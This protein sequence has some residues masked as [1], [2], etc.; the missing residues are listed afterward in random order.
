MVPDVQP[1]WGETSGTIG[2]SGQVLLTHASLQLL[3]QN[4]G[5]PILHVKGPTTDPDLR[6]EIR[7]ATDAD[8]LVP[9]SGVEQMMTAMAAHGWSFLDTFASGS[10]FGH[11]ATARHKTWGDADIHRHMPGTADPDRTFAKFSDRARV[12]DLAGVPCLVL[13]RVDQALVI[14]LHAARSGLM[15][16]ELSRAF[17]DVRAT[18][19]ALTLPEREELQRR[20]TE[21]GAQLPVSIALGGD[22]TAFVGSRDYELWHIAAY[23]G[24][25]TQEWVARI[26]SAPTMRMR[27]SLG[28]RMALVN[29][30]S[31][32]AR[33]HRPATRTDMVME[34]GARAKAG[35]REIY[36]WARDG[37]SRP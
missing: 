5:L 11:S 35:V 17:L 16:I 34:F 33:L 13:D 22:T 21:L 27:V 7:A 15:G 26:K 29:R 18:W 8:I 9:P 23:G 30:H 20:A 12:R 36:Q 2:L 37:S 4:E 32:E 19:S 25:R 3:A 14:M 28:V 31:L 1:L 24:S 6:H 10:P